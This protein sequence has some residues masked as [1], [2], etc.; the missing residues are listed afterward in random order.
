[1]EIERVAAIGSSCSIYRLLR[2]ARPPKLNVGAII[3]ESD[4]TLVHSQEHRLALWA[5]H[6][7]GG[8]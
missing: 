4:G 1:M 5:K 2:N 7:K 3:K 8:F 6:F